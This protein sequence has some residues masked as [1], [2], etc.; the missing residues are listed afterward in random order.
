[1][2]VTSSELA[3]AAALAVLIVGSLY[4]D[5]AFGKIYNRLVFPMIPIG[6]IIW[7]VGEGFSG[8]VFSLLGMA[9]GFTA[10][11]VSAVL[12]WVAPGDAKLIFAIGAL[13]GPTFT[14][15]TMLFGA[16]AGGLL[17]MVFLWRKQ[18]LRSWM[19]RAAAGTTGGLPMS[20]VWSGRSGYIP[21]SIAIA[22]GVVGAAIYQIT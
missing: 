18:M 20:T 2:S 8:T 7:S 9:V 13:T 3:S 21:Y 5:I 10:L 19:A 1:L 14:A 16:L 6:L 17:A 15:L 4:T 12:R 22:C 11:L